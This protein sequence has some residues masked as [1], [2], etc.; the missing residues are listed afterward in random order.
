M[1]WRKHLAKQN[2][3]KILKGVREKIEGSRGEKEAEKIKRK[4][5]R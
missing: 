1:S 4:R 2:L 3:K 5:E